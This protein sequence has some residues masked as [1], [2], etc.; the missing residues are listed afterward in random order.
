[1]DFIISKAYENTFAEILNY[2]TCQAKK[3]TKDLNFYVI[4][5]YYMQTAAYVETVLKEHLY[6]AS[7][8][9]AILVKDLFKTIKNENAIQQAVFYSNMNSN[10]A[11]DSAF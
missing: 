10:P 7:T 2:M 9:S 4:N 5:R 11:F 6:E 1:M 8:S 3:R